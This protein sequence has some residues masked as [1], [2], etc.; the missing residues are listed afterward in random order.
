MSDLQHP[1]AFDPKRDH[2]SLVALQRRLDRWSSRPEE[3]LFEVV[4]DASHWSPAHHLYH[5][6]LANEF[7][8]GN[9]M[10]LV[11]ETGVLRRESTGLK[12]E[13]EAILRRGILPGGAQAPRFVTPPDKLGPDGLAD[14]LGG[15]REGVQAVGA[16]IDRVA[17]APMIIPH[18]ILGAL[19]AS[20][21]LRFA[22]VHTAHHLRILRR[23]GLAQ[24]R[25]G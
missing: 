7:S 13:A 19:D 1:A 12:P 16:V 17:K 18:Q 14:A 3:K 24:A 22:R 11:N 9:V 23:I 25:L 6:G 15:S 2:T 4:S 21:W 10:S 20:R 8:L 5:I